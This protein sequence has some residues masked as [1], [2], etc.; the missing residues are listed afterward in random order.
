MRYCCPE[1]FDDNGF[2]TDIFP[3]LKQS[4][5]VCDFC[6]TEDVDLVDPRSLSVYFEL[7]AGVYEQGR[8]GKTLVEWMKED[9][10][11]FTHP[12]MDMA[13]AKELLAEILDDGEVV[14]Q[15]FVPSSDCLSDGL[16][17]WE[18]LRDEMMYRNRWFL[19][20]AFDNE[21]LEGWL[22]LLIAK[23]IPEKWFRARLTSGAPC[24]GIED[25]SAPPKRLSSHGRANPAG[26][27]YLY[28]GSL[29]ETAVSEVRPHTGDT[30]CVAD[31]SID[32]EGEIKVVDLRTPRSTVSPFVLSDTLAIGQLRAYMPLLE[33]LGEELTRPVLP[34]G[35]AIDY[36]PSQYLCEFIKK[37][38][39]HGVIY[40]SSV[41]DGINLALFDPGKAVGGR[42]EMYEVGRVSVDVI[43]IRVR[44]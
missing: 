10:G 26:I 24:Y 43:R 22:S 42:V 34:S 38:G 2:R 11:L 13:H 31:F 3:A 35:A 19:D 12:R 41:S 40:R 20:V 8:D 21:R 39:Y 4:H 30:A 16:V 37:C 1:C 7:L 9:W 14:R 6:G 29:P 15:L 25:M 33:R 28:L 27:P 36:I 23:D 5:G 44:E 32:V 18:T 17:Q